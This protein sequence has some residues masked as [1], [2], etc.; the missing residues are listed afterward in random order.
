MTRRISQD[1]AYYL[2]KNGVYSNFVFYTKRTTDPAEMV[3]W[4]NWRNT[5]QG[6]KYWQ[7]IL[8]WG[9]SAYLLEKYHTNSVI[10]NN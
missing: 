9:F 8:I 5:K 4:F 7:D 2:K 10:F 6:Y 3:S 1:F